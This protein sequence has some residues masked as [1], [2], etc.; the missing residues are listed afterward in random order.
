MTLTFKKNLQ[1]KKLTFKKPMPKQVDSQ[2]DHDSIA[3]N[4]NKGRPPSHRLAYVRNYYAEH[5]ENY[6]A[7]RQKYYAKNKI[8]LR[9]KSLMRKYL[10]AGK[11]QEEA[12]K[13]LSVARIKWQAQ[14]ALGV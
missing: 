14:S 9:E 12:L 1:A 13:L 6:K 2:P 10:K 8:L 11:S 4:E 3:P 7:S 5:K